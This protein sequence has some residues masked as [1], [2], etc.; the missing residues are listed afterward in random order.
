M[1]KR[2]TLKYGLPSFFENVSLLPYR[3]LGPQRRNSKMKQI[4][5]YIINVS[6]P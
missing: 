6:V 5:A 4:I 3:L 1:K 2:V